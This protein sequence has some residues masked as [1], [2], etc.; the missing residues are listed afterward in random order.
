MLPNSFY[1]TIIDKDI[2]HTHTHTKYRLIILMNTDVEILN[3]ILANQIQQYPT[4]LSG[5]YPRG[6]R[7]D[8]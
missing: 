6:A 2:T 1:E 5:I 3:K 8:Q 4:G 7:M